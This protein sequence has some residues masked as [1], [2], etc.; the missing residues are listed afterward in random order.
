MRFWFRQ[1]LTEYLKQK[2]WLIL[3]VT[4][5]FCM[6][7]VFG[8][9][10]VK[11]ISADQADHLSG[12]LNGF[13]EKV[14]T[15]PLSEQVYFRYNVLNN[16]YVM[17]AI[18]LLGLTV[19]GIP[20]VLVTVFS[21]GFVLG[22]TVGFLVRAKAVKGFAF[23][24]VSMLPH[25]ILIIPSVILGGVTAL[26][27]SALMLKKRFGPQNSKMAGNIGAY[28]MVML[29]LCMVTGAAGLIETYLTP[30]IVRTAALY[31]K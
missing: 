19:I 4:V 26:S 14:S 1:V 28:I 23:A 6:G 15:T 5:F 20:L 12:Y 9:V 11:T 17:I 22:F 21:R 2:W 29:I 7:I 16:L 18:F 27:F 30:V 13:L 10:A 25:N 8:A 3:F 31:L 24:L